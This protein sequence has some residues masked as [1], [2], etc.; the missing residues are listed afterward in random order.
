[1]YHNPD[2]QS[3]N[4]VLVLSRAGK[5]TGKNRTWFN[6]KNV[7]EYSHQSDSFSNI[8]GWENV[9][10][11]MVVTIHSDTNFDILRAK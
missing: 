4:K 10:K 6:I 5:S 9:K 7:E 3:Q 2:T 11:E 8:K 1:M